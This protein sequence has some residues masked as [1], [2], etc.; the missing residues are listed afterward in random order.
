MTFTRSSVIE[1]PETILKGKNYVHKNSKGQIYYLNCRTIKLKGSN[2]RSTF[3]WFSGKPSS[4]SCS[5]PKNK[6]VWE[7]PGHGM[8]FVKNT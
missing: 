8:C 2:Y 7:K 6:I 5:L 3:Y 4:E 1:K